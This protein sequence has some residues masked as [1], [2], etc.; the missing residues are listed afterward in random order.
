MGFGSGIWNSGFLALTNCTFAT[1][2]AQGGNGG[3]TPGGLTF[4]GHGGNGEGVALYNSGQSIVVSCTVASNN[5]S[6][7]AAGT[8]GPALRGGAYGGGIRTSTGMVTVGNS[9]IAN[10]AGSETPDVSGDFTSQGY[11]LIGT[12]NGS[13]GFGAPFDQTGRT[14]NPINPQLG[15]LRDNGGPTMS[16]A[17]PA[18]SPAVDQGNSFGET[19]DQR[20]APRPSDFPFLSNTADAADIGAY[21]VSAPLLSISQ[22]TSNVLLSWSTFNPTYSLQSTT[23]LGGSNWVS[24]V[25]P[26][27][28]GNRFFITNPLSIGSKFFRLCSP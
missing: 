6:G 1:N 8:G 2:T 16:L 21:E 10:N 7:G 17:L 12:T 28:V 14:N 26:T 24:I 3:A 23:N 18:S 13:S 22:A 27:V 15:P 25:G 5:A 19:G 4:P 9:I 11:N 20:G